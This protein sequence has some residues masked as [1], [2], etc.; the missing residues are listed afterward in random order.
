MPSVVLCTP[1][2]KR[3]GGVTTA[4]N[5]LLPHLPE[6]ERVVVGWR[7]PRRVWRRRGEGR[8]LHLNPSVRPR[9]LVRD[10]TL[11]AG[12][13][14]PAVMWLHGWSD[15]TWRWLSTTGRALVRRAC[16]RAL[17]VVLAERFRVRLAAAGVAEDR[18]RVVP[19][20]FDP[21][22]VPE[23][24]TGPDLLFLGRL[25]QEKGPFQAIEAFARIAGDHPQTRLV[26]AGAGPARDRLSER[27]AA[28]D[29]ANRVRLP[30]H[31]DRA[32]KRDALARAAVVVLPSWGEGVP[33]SL[34]EA[35]AAGRPV[36][37]TEVG[38]VPETVGEG[39]TIV[40]PGDVVGL[41]TA[42]DGLL[43]DP[44]R[45][46]AIGAASRERAWARW[47]ASR[48]AARWRAIYSELGR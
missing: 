7:D 6:A 13:R 38:A 31:L 35:M 17:P 40:A 20:P 15:P 2:P 44:A 21:A 48:V 43:R 18:I 3:P 30:G 27:A 45:A 12:W 28:L 9:A 39:G 41:A 16:A 32:G 4:L 8:V 5:T 46:E 42:I 22:G 33:V 10:L 1:D 26:L 47:E 34:L 23:P 25:V 11:L 36:V 19:P 24:G 29:L 14:G 37:A